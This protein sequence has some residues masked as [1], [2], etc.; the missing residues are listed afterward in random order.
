[1]KERKGYDE[2]MADS[3]ETADAVQQEKTGEEIPNNLLPTNKGQDGKDWVLVIA[4][5]ANAT[6]R[7]L[8][9]G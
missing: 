9:A 8:M 5:K 1:M 7:S 4:I 2:A 6:M 3:G